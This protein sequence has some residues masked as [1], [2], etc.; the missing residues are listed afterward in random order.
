MACLVGSLLAGVLAGRAGAAEATVGVLTYRGEQHALDCWRPT[1]RLL[2][3]HLPGYRFGARPLTRVGLRSAVENGELQFVLTDAG[4]YLDLQSRFGVS[5]VAALL[6]PGDD[7]TV[8]R[9]AA[10]VFVRRDRA[11]LQSFDDLEGKEVIGVGE[12]SFDDYQIAMRELHRAGIDPVQDL[13]KLSFSGVPQDDVVTAVREGTADAGIVRADVLADIGGDMFRILNAREGDGYPFARSTPT[14]PDWQL[15]STR[16]TPPTLAREVAAVLLSQPLE[17]RLEGP[18]AGWGLAADMSP[19]H[20]VL[21]DL[22]AGP[23]RQEEPPAEWWRRNPWMVPVLLLALLSAAAALYILYLTQ[24]L[25]WSYRRFE[26]E[27][28]ERRT[29]QEQAQQHQAALAHA[30]RVGT[31]GEIATGLAHE[32]NQPLAAIVN[33]AQGSVRRLRSG[34]V[35]PRQL[36]PP[37]LDITMQAERAAEIIRHLRQLVR[38]AEPKYQPADIN[39]IVSAALRLAHLEA[40]AGDMRFEVELDETLPKVMADAIQI[41]QVVLNVLINAI[42]AGCEVTGRECTVAVRTGRD[43]QGDIE[44]TVSDSGPGFATE[45]ALLL[46]KPFYTT[47][48]RGLGMGLA[49]SHTIVES[50]HGRL[51]AHSTPGGGATFRLVLPA[52]QQTGNV[53]GASDRIHR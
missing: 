2:S 36:L 8:D 24:R 29:A 30:L 32:L 37:L 50:H 3:Q 34:A 23:Y 20:E 26:A 52:V 27:A 12:D 49:I 48:A 10:A 6:R 11:D 19:V 16:Q 1:A 15:A 18:C 31:V 40:G 17:A 42:E 13:S 53:D 38:R 4:Q 51:T 22:G 5:R 28:R 46:F 45:E 14:Y 47:K 7:G 25:R 21:R 33:Y 43:E 41:E 35:E 44:V 9:T 39:E